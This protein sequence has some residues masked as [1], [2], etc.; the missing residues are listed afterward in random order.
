[1]LITSGK[2]FTTRKDGNF[3]RENNIMVKTDRKRERWLGGK[4]RKYKSLERK[5][6][7]AGGIFSLEETEMAVK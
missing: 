1:M 6:G 4:E 3:R 7:E 2:D 5:K